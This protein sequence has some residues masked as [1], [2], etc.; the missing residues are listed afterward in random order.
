MGFNYGYEKKKFDSRWKR[1]EVEYC[2]AGMS[3]EQIAAMKEYDWAWFCSQR[4]F[5]NHTQPIPC[6]QYDERKTL[7][8]M[9]GK[10]TSFT[11]SGLP[12]SFLSRLS[13]LNNARH[14]TP[15]FTLLVGNS[16]LSPSSRTVNALSLVKS[17]TAYRG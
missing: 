13:K 3:E 5:Q 7:R 4:V 6:E 1:L 14:D 17:T 10:R 12:F 15:S 2:D 9:T 16:I 8:S 11:L